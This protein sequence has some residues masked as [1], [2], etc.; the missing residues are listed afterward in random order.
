MHVQ[1]DFDPK[2]DPC[3]AF[4][5]KISILELK[6]GGF[7]SS[8][9]KDMTS[10]TQNPFFSINSAYFPKKNQPCIRMRLLEFLSDRYIA[11]ILH[12]SHAWT[13]F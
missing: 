13:T 2:F 9:P 7:N 4:F 6:S 12:K 5:Y 10:R 3:A 8:L 11:I 1:E